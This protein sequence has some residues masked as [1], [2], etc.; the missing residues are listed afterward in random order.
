MG[1]LEKTPEQL[2]QE[3]NAAIQAIEELKIFS[4]IIEEAN[5]GI[6]ILQEGMI[7]YANQRM[8]NLT[9]VAINELQDSS[10][11]KHIHPSALLPINE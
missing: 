11:K 2:T 1:K 6:V 7:K 9:G 10:F 5:D 3:L 4:S 8:A